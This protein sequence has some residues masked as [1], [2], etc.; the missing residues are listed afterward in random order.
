LVAW[1]WGHCGASLLSHVVEDPPH[2][3]KMGAACGDEPFAHSSC[4]VAEGE[5]HHEPFLAYL[6]DEALGVYLPEE[7]LEALLQYHGDDGDVRAV[8]LRAA[9]R[10][11]QQAPAGPRGEDAEDH[12]PDGRRSGA[13]AQPHR[14]PQRRPV[15]ETS[16]ATLSGQLQD[17]LL[18][19]IGLLH[20]EFR[21]TGT[22]GSVAR[23]L[24][25]GRAVCVAGGGASPFVVWSAT[26]EGV[27]GFFCSCGTD[28][29]DENVG[30]RVRT[31]ESSTCRHAVA[32]AL[33]LKGVAAHV[34]CE[35]MPALFERFPALDNAHARPVDVHC[36]EV[37]SFDDGSAMHGV[38]HNRIWCV[39]KTPARKTRKV[40]PVCQHVPCRTRN[41]HCIHSCVVKPPVDG[42]RGFDG[43]AP[44]G[45]DK[46]DEPP[47]VPEDPVTDTPAAA[48]ASTRERP[49]APSARKQGKE[50]QYIDTDYLRRARNLLPC[51]GESAAC[52]DWDSV[53]R[54]GDLLPYMNAELYEP[55]CISC[56]AEAGPRGDGTSATLHTLSGPVGVRVAE[57]VCPNVACGKTVAFDGS[58]QGLFCFSRQAVYTRTFLDVLLFTL[59]TT[60]SSISAAASAS[61]FQLHTSGA[62][63]ADDAHSRQELSKATDQYSRTLIVPRQLFRCTDCFFCSQTPYEAVVADGQTIGI[64]KDQSI[65]FEKATA[66]VPTIPISVDKA[67]AVPT[68]KV[69]KCVRERLKA[70]FATDVKFN[71]AEQLAMRKFVALGGVAPPVGDHEDAGHR[72][73]CAAWAASCLFNSF[74]RMTS[75]PQHEDSGSSASDVPP[76]SP[77]PSTGE[78]PFTNS[79]PSPPP[80]SPR[81][82]PPPSSPPPTTTSSATATAG[83]AGRPTGLRGGGAANGGHAGT[84]APVNALKYCS[85]ISDAVGGDSLLP[86]VRRERWSILFNF[87]SAFIAEPV[88]GIF[89]GCPVGALTELAKALIVCKKSEEWLKITK[90]IQSLHVVWPALDL[91]AESMDEDVEMCRAMGEL[92]LFSVHTDLHMEDLW[93]GAMNAESLLFEA[94]WTDTDAT[95]FKS[96]L[97]QQPVGPGPH[98]PSGLRSSAASTER[99]AD[100]ATEIR[101]GVVTPDLDQVRPHPRDD[102]AAAV[103]RAAKAKAQTAKNPNAKKTSK[104]KRQQEENG[105]LGDDDC[106]HAFV[107]HS[108][109]TPGVVSYICP[110]GVLLGFEVL[111]TAESPAGIV[112]ALAARFPRLPKTVY[113]DTA[114]QSARNA[115]R[116]MPWLVRI[117]D[118]AWA[119]DRFHAV[120]HKCSPLYDANNYPTRSGMHKTS[121]AENRH[122]LNKPLKAHLTYL[123]QDRFI[124]QMRL[125][126]AINNMLIMYRG[127]VN[128][129]DVRHRPLPAFFHSRLTMHCERLGCWCR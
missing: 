29:L 73:S 9:K 119:L 64:F 110:C 54:G 126:G 38:G 77:R 5:E 111:E 125:I 36:E 115:T 18:V 109:F 32:H 71:K 82:S 118:T 15:T 120:Q 84:A 128:R 103:A 27:A 59:I 56:G 75:E 68:A 57:W 100:Q 37:S 48:D 43:Q 114:C 63:Y 62:L 85:V 25:G 78:P 10:G 89:A 45:E 19:G 17:A 52:R 105:R 113:F 34:G 123:A 12:H 41:A 83:T 58:E 22:A 127:C 60:K 94:A 26:K 86:V 117:S 49:A 61:A 95:K 93:R 108:V 124:V 47:D 65:P 98:L 72:A 39:V 55:H 53:A 6:A 4:G 20:E 46:V 1:W 23:P 50:R 16:I 70:G 30:A 3:G 80:Q 14:A 99:A 90:C 102:V 67:S 112:A 42:Y 7:L 121:A 8:P 81:P 97:A 31:G 74:F 40:R 107:T 79:K 87:F 122:S 69:R 66:N 21:A 33:A 129:A 28:A 104:R 51:W 24:C 2:V 106:R 91:L 101:S 96:W 116:R 13:A 76:T 35:S 88:I 44:D 11:R 92:L